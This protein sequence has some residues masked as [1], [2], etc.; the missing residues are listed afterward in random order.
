MD[1]VIG[2]R[3]EEMGEELEN[4]VQGRVAIEVSY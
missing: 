2:D 1:R 4:L 3:L